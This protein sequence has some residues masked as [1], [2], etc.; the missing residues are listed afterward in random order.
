M[1][2][3]VT[4]FILEIKQAVNFSLIATSQRPDFDIFVFSSANWN[5]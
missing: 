1:I 5:L 2:Y 4:F 3:S